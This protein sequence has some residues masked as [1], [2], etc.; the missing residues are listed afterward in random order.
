[1]SSLKYFG[2]EEENP[3]LAI[4]QPIRTRQ[5]LLGIAETYLNRIHNIGL[6][7]SNKDGIRSAKQRGLDIQSIAKRLSE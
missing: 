6:D 3:Q 2:L 5:C 1:M 4:T 7:L